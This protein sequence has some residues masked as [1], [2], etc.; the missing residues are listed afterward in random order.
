MFRL[1]C[2]PLLDG[3]E[4]YHDLILLGQYG[5]ASVGGTSSRTFA[6]DSDTSSSGLHRPL[7]F[8]SFAYLEHR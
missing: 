5:I 6:E 4:D 7:V 2:P 3:D 8:A 1:Y